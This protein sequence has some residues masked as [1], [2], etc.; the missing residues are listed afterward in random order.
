MGSITHAVDSS[1]LIKNEYGYDAFG[2]RTSLSTAPS[3]SHGHYGYTGQEY[4]EETG[5]LYLRAR[6]YDPMIGRFISADLF[7]GR[8]EQPAS[9][10]RYT[11][12]HNS[13]LIFTDPSGLDVSI[14]MTCASVTIVITGSVCWGNM[15]DGYGN[16][17]LF[18]DSGIGKGVF[19][20]AGL[21]NFTGTLEGDFDVFVFQ[22]HDTYALSF[23]GGGRGFEVEYLKLFSSDFQ[24][25]LVGVGVG[26]GKVPVNGS[27]STFDPSF[28][29]SPN[30]PYGAVERIQN[31]I[32][33]EPMICSGL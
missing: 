10:N 6:Y 20:S 8:L 12:V 33:Q 2:I 14:N 31:A 24:V 18:Y 4:D 11:Y 23:S 5:L 16:N 3:A 25:D 29:T 32:E 21:I 9:Q 1:G 22:D 27:V 15:T 17:A 13:P 19:P 30:R 26:S 28:I 7:W